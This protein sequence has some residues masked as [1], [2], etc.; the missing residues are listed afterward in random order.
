MRK[1]LQQT[2]QSESL[3]PIQRQQQQQTMNQ[4]AAH[5]KAQMSGRS[6]TGQ[7]PPEKKL[8]LPFM[9]QNYLCQKICYCNCNAKLS[10]SG[11][12]LKQ[13]CVSKAIYQDCVKNNWIWKYKGEV[14]YNMRY[15][16]PRPL[17]SRDGVNPSSFPLGAAMREG[18]FSLSEIE[19]QGGNLLRIPDVI[20][21][22]DR[23]NK[24]TAQPNIEYV[25][26]IKFPGDSW[27]RDQEKDYQK[28]AGHPDKLKDLTLQDCDCQDCS[29]PDK[30]WEPVKV[31]SMPPIPLGRYGKQ[32]G[33]Y[34]ELIQGGRP[35]Y[36]PVPVAAAQSAMSL[37]E[38]LL[39]G[40]LV[41]GGALMIGFLS[42]TGVGAVGGGLMVRRGIQMF[43]V[44]GVAAATN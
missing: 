21:V 4:S 1:P 43:V 17:L 30:Q 27:R 15:S 14:G 35:V 39:A 16:P 22:K 40:G 33:M 44:G 2:H 41:L 28:I 37:K 29:E 26:E 9:D 12:F 24:S 42:E 23:N 20:I 5:A 18:I 19:K 25:V 31:P 6:R 11:Q 38:F 13:R 32:Y 7:Q 36:Q 34:E 3:F 8:K 10:R